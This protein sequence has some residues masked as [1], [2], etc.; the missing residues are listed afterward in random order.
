[1]KKD[2]LCTNS[3]SASPANLQ[4]T[5]GRLRETPGE[6][7]RSADLTFRTPLDRRGRVSCDIR[8]R[9]GDT[10]QQRRRLHQRHH[11]GLGDVRFS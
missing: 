9:F 3:N 5:P 8:L 1:M 6:G 10:A 7:R 11:T 2:Q 4:K